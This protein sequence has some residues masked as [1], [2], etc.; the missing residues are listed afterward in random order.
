MGTNKNGCAC[1][2]GFDTKVKMNH[3]LPS[4]VLA[5]N[6]VKP[7]SNFGADGWIKKI[8]RTTTRDAGKE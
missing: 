4:I 2:A 6:C 8:Y 3:Q 1:N 7:V 5:G